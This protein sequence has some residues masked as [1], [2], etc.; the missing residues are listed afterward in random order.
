MAIILECN[1]N[2]RKSTLTMVKDLVGE[3]N[4]EARLVLLDPT[5]S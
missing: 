4:V 1:Y 5:K 2:V 3:Y